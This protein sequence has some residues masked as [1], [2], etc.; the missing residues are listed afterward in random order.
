[1]GDSIKGGDRGD[2]DRRLPSSEQEEAA[3]EHGRFG[4]E[5]S[6]SG[7]SVSTVFL[8]HLDCPHARKPFANGLLSIFSFVMRS[9]CEQYKWS[10]SEIDF[11]FYDYRKWCIMQ[12]MICLQSP[13][14]SIKKTINL[15]KNVSSNFIISYWGSSRRA[16]LNCRFY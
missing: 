4:S 10:V 13:L 5:G 8:L 12:I 3:S 11:I 16:K 14:V 15:I 1:M 9:F 2:E 6:C 7:L